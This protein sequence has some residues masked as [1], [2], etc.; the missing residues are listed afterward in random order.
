MAIGRWFAGKVAGSVLR[1]GAE[2]RGRL[3]NIQRRFITVLTVPQA[4]GHP[5]DRIRGSRENSLHAFCVHN[6]SGV[7]AFDG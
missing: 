4:E 1:S 3:L 5:N 2:H 6:R 7:I